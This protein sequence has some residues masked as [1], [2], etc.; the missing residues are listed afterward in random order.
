[1]AIG[2]NPS[3][4]DSQS[5]SYTGGMQSFTVPADGIYKLEVWGAVGASGGDWNGNPGGTGGYSVGYKTLKKGTTLY[6]CCGGY[7][8][9]SWAS[10][11]AD[12]GYN[13][14]GYGRCAEPREY[15]GASGGGGATHIAT[16]SGVLSSLSA[17]KNT[18][19]ILIV[20]GGGG[21]GGGSSGN[22]GSGGGT[23]GGGG[24]GTYGY[25]G[26]TQS[27][28][29]SGGRV[30]GNAGFGQGSGAES[31]AYGNGGG[32]GGWYGGVSGFS[33]SGGGSG[34]IGNVPS[35]T[36]AGKTYAPST[37]NGVNSGHGKASITFVAK[38]VLFNFNGTDITDLIYNGTN[39]TSLN[40]NGTKIF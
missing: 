8:K 38:N 11:G 10:Y 16:V 26:G 30:N 32:G 24:D 22:G 33:G 18:G 5:F 29:G 23:S 40:L 21:G 35:F 3:S 6:I 15:R 28:I 13:G 27:G 9:G 7:G 14:G 25:H 17:Y 39:I 12:G 31:M 1:M 34:W 20:A 36:N 37:S 19:E 4:G 2:S